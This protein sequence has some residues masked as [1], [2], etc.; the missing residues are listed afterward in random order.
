MTQ[1][2]PLFAVEINPPDVTDNHKRQA[3]ALG[4]EIGCALLYIRKEQ[5]KTIQRLAERA[6]VKPNEWIIDAFNAYAQAQ[7][8]EELHAQPEDLIRPAHP[9]GG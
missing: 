5:A 7:E 2:Q 9:M 1:Q 3:V 4:N 6:G 8:R